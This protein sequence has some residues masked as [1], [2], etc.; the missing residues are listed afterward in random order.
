MTEQSPAEA[1]FFAALE[2]ATAEDRLA[3]L[4]DACGEDTNLRQRVVRLLAAHP[5][6]GN[7]MEPSPSILAGRAHPSGAESSPA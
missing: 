6:V 4:N 2:K 7:F 5:Q 1:I 3:Y